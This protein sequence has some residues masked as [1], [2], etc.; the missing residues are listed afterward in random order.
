M[1]LSEQTPPP[2]ADPSAEPIA[3]PP[4]SRPTSG[5]AITGLILAFVIAP[6]GFVLSLIAIFKTGATK[7]K[8]R[9]LAIAGVIVSVLVMG[10][11]AAVFAVVAQSTALDPGCIDGK[12]AIFDSGASTDATGLQ[13]T[14]DALRAAAAK[15]DDG[16]VRDA[17]NTLADD[18]TQLKTGIESGSLPEGLEAKITADGERIDTLCT[19]GA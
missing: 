13:T 18:Y 11:V 19:P 4:A 12:Q 7:A 8:G 16:D 17:M 6:I 3:P 9:G 10:G 15:S 14:I 5:L 2:P 1:S